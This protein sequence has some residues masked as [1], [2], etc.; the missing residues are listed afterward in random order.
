L[1]EEERAKANGE[2]YNYY[3]LKDAQTIITAQTKTGNDYLG[4]SPNN[5]VFFSRTQGSFHG[6]FDNIATL[7][8]RETNRYILL[9]IGRWKSLSSI[10]GGGKNNVFNLLLERIDETG[11]YWRSAGIVQMYPVHELELKW[12]AKRLTLV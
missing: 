2:W 4:D 5:S 8:L 12:E 11:G 3:W 7:K 9:Q 1:Q 6:S 10:P